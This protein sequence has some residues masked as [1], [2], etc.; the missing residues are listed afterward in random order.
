MYDA[1]TNT[2]NSTQS[3]APNYKLLTTKEAASFLS[4]SEAFLERDRWEGK[5]N[6]VGALIPYVQV[7]SRAIR[8]KLSDLQSHI[9]QNSN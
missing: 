8:Y 9:D 2:N 5:Q 7:G 3:V 1:K 4:V 6:A